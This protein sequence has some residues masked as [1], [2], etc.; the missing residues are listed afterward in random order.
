MSPSSPQSA[1]WCFTVNNW[2]ED[3]IKALACLPCKYVAYGKETGANGTAHLQG[4]VVFVANK[5]LPAVKKILPTAHWEIAKGDTEQNV[6]YCSKDGDFTEHGERPKTRKQVGQSNADRYQDAVSKAKAGLLEEIDGELLTKYY[7]TYQQMKKDF[8]AKPAPLPGTCGLW[9]YGPTGTGKTHSV[10]TQHP[11][12]YIKPLNKWWDGYQDE[13]VVHLDEIAPSHAA[14]IAPYL[15]KWAD[16][17]PFDAEMKGSAA[18]LRP[19]KIV[20]TSNY[21]IDEMGF[22]WE[23]LD[24][25]KR[26]YVEIRKDNREQEIF[27]M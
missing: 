11:D 20:V 2:N 19:K 18:Q 6:A 12:R 8:M 14:W 13:D 9:I 3:N 17:W 1:R 15:K 24:A 16:K 27:V 25:I 22:A 4:Y 23:D 7:R 5:R 10:C 21:S 26:R